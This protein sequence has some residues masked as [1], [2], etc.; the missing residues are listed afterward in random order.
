[1]PYDNMHNIN[2]K[3]TAKMGKPFVNIHNT[4]YSKNVVILL[5]IEKNSLRL[6]D[7]II[8]NCIR[9]A[10]Y[11]ASFFTQNGIPFSFYANGFDIE[12]D[13]I[14]AI[15][16]GC[17][18][19]HYRSIEI[20][21]ARLDLAKGNIPFSNFLN[22]DEIFNNHYAEYIIISNSQKEDVSEP[23]MMRK[24]SGFY[25]NY[26]SPDYDNETSSKYNIPGILNWIIPRV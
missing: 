16:N 8:E 13:E 5:N 6:G 10:S 26:I 1:M 4:T 23:Y 21:L 3:A 14:I 20:A 15:N 11:V 25:M 7:E 17:S 24:K 19:S 9:I 12:N 22:D 18:L 2:W